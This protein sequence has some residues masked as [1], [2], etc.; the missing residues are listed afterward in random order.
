MARVNKTFAAGQ[1]VYAEGQ[2]F[3][4]DHD[5]VKKYPAFFDVDKP[6]RRQRPKD[7]ETDS[8]EDE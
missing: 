6:K 2:E 8:G 4:D 3:P 5:A 1:R 7:T